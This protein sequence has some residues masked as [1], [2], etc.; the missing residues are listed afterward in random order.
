MSKKQTRT[1]TSWGQLVR[2]RII[3]ELDEAT[4]SLTLSNRTPIRSVHDCRRRVKRVRAGVRLLRPA[5]PQKYRLEDFILADAAR[6]L[7]PIRDGHVAFLRHPDS[8]LPP[9]YS[10]QIRHLIMGSNLVLT[11]LASRATRWDVS[12]INDQTVE[13]EL[14]RVYRRGWR[15]WQ[16]AIQTLGDCSGEDCSCHGCAGDSWTGYDHFHD[17]RKSVKRLYY[18]H[19][20]LEDLGFFRSSKKATKSRAGYRSHLD[21]L[22]ERL[23]DHHDLTINH[24]ID[25]VKQEQIEND[26]RDLGEKVFALKPKNHRSWTKSQ[27]R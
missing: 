13:A 23:G 17:A 10:H 18:Q 27:I 11:N 2:D 9:P 3:A 25:Q 7:G 5:G 22:G 15:R 14:A 8:S 21:L 26:L 1:D 12:G 16:E 20:I 4:M 6:R 19:G 24:G